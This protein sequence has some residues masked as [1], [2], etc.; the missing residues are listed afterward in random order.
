MED[1]KTETKRPL[2]VA[3][4]A[5]QFGNTDYD[6]LQLHLKRLTQDDTPAVFKP[7]LTSDA[8]L[9]PFDFIEEADTNIDRIPNFMILWEYNKCMHELQQV[10]DKDDYHFPFDESL[11]NDLFYINNYDFWEQEAQANAWT[12]ILEQLKPAEFD[13]HSC[14]VR[15]TGNFEIESVKDAYALRAQLVHDFPDT[16]FKVL[17]IMERIKNHYPKLLEEVPCTINFLNA[18]EA[19][20]K[21]QA[22]FPLIQIIHQETTNNG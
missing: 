6:F 20:L 21:H 4:L 8:K 5:D 16:I 12:T 19:N 17:A 2:H 18:F 15:K 13:M 1:L 10:F 11:E 7:F 9:P 14:F 3:T 22:G